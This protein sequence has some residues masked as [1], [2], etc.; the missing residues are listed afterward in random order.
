MYFQKADYNNILCIYNLAWNV[1]TE[2]YSN[3]NKRNQS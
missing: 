2:L 3:Q 1:L